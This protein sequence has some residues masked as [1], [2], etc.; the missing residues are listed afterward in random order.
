MYALGIGNSG[1]GIQEVVELLVGL[2]VLLVGGRSRRRRSSMT[3]RHDA[4]EDWF[5]DAAEQRTEQALGG[6]SNLGS[7]TGG[8]GLGL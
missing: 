2:V 7:P 1:L 5:G 3:R 8:R 4:T 6:G